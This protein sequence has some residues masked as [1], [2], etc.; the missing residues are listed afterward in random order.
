[1]KKKKE[2]HNII[3]KIKQRIY[4]AN[5]GII[6]F[7][8]QKMGQARKLND[9]ELNLL[10]LYIKTR[11]FASRDRA[12]ILM[13]YWS[14]AR[15]KEVALTLVTPSATAIGATFTMTFT[16]PLFLATGEYLWATISATQTSGAYDINC[17]GGDY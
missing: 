15:I 1:M 2:L 16:T 10:L 8:E 17:Y 5:N 9:K 12:M 7:K 3:G 6:T 13:T 11:K 14:G 4:A